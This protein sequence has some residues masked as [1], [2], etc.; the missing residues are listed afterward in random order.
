MIEPDLP[1]AS[2]NQCLGDSCSLFGAK[3]AVR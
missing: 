3:I 2:A 1:V